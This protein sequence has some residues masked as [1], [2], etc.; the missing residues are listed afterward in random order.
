MR[1]VSS[2]KRY[3]QALFELALE[4][5]ELGNCRTS[6]RKAAG[7]VAEGK[8]MDIL[9]NPRLPFEAKKAVL[10]KLLGAMEPLVAN[11]ISLL[12]TRGR[13][14]TLGDIAEHYERLLDRHRGILRAEV[15]TAVPLNDNDRKRFSTLFSDLLG[16]TVIIDSRVDPSVLG[17]FRA[18]IGDLLIDGSIR[19]ALES[20]RKTLVGAGSHPY[21]PPSKGVA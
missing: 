1:L 13:L 4:R 10:R 6:L 20:L 21:P 7:T 17:G 12:M 9:E 2:G 18:R 11:L 5:E 15:L 3:A 19:N 8:L 14:R 16:H